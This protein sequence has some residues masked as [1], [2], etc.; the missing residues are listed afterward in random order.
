[1][2][3]RVIAYRREVQ[4][5]DNGQAFT[6][7][8][9]SPDPNAPTIEE[10]VAVLREAEEWEDDGEGLPHRICDKI[11]NLIARLEDT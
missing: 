10:I 3:E 1:M 7:Y 11:N 9:Y 8:G 6:A 5:T 2:S 4:W